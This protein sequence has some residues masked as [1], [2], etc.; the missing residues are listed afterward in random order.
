MK[1]P[2]FKRFARCLK[3]CCQLLYSRGPAMQYAKQ[4]EV[5]RGVPPRK[6]K[7]LQ[8]SGLL[9]L[10][11]APFVSQQLLWMHASPSERP[12]AASLDYLPRNTQPEHHPPAQTCTFVSS[13]CGHWE[14][15][16]RRQI[17]WPF[18]IPPQHADSALL[19]ASTVMIPAEVR[20]YRVG[21]LKD[22]PRLVHWQHVLCSL[23]WP[24]SGVP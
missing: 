6:C 7:P 24:A 5:W 9:R 11:Q 17:L 4:E 21:K 20:I 15:P 18:T 1:L 13:S 14:S 22:W 2:G 10:S 3:E 16:C 23:L 8:Q 19:S 12:S